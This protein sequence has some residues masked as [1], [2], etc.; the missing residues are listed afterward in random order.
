MKDQT[1]LVRAFLSV[2]GYSEDQINRGLE[3]AADFQCLDPDSLGQLT[4]SRILLSDEQLANGE[5]AAWERVAWNES[6]FQP[7]AVHYWM[8][9]GFERY[10][11]GGG[12]EAMRREFPDGC[13]CLVTDNDGLS[14]PTFRDDPVAVGYYD[15][16]GIDIHYSEHPNSAAALATVESFAELHTE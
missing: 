4:L 5:R 10:H 3:Y 15:S 1:Q 6:E 12:C 11:T 9:Q 16:E 7:P 14:P 2:A 8:E 13:Y